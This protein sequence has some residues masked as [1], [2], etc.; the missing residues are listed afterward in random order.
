MFVPYG[1]TDELEKCVRKMLDDR[2]TEKN[3]KN[4]EQIAEEAAELY[5]RERMASKYIEK[6]EWL[7]RSYD[8]R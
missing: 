4:S 6:Y 7:M 3:N 8:V 2:D 1:D 5:D